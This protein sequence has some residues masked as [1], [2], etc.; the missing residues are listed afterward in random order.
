VDEAVEAGF[1]QAE[2]FEEFGALEQAVSSWA[3]S[4]SS[5]PQIADYLTTLFRRLAFLRLRCRRC[6]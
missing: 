4:A 3:I 5:A 6:R 2:G 1:F